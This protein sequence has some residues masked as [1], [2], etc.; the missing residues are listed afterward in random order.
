[1]DVKKKMAEKSEQFNSLLSEKAEYEKK[2]I[3]INEE[4]L[5]I[6]GEYRMLQEIAGPEAEP[7]VE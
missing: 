4:L 1:M 2:I 7:A 6:Q 3:A 5:R